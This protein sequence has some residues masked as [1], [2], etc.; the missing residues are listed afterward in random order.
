MRCAARAPDGPNHLELCGLQTTCT[1]STRSTSATVN[2]PRHSPTWG[3]P[4][5][6]EKSRGLM[7]N[8]GSFFQSRLIANRGSFLSMSTGTPAGAIVPHGIAVVM[9]APAIFKFTAVMDPARESFEPGGYTASVVIP[10]AVC[11]LIHPAPKRSHGVRRD[12][13][14]RHVRQARHGRD[15]RCGGLHSLHHC[16]PSPALFLLPLLAWPSSLSPRPRPYGRDVR[17]PSSVSS[18]PII[19]C[20]PPHHHPLSSLRTSNPPLLL[21]SALISSNPPFPL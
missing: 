19:L 20:F 16:S 14:G 5:L 13:R 10:T 2:K 21:S 9:P 12:P 15:G 7:A 8:R 6:G 18:P 1:G 17:L 3:S 11:M 4:S